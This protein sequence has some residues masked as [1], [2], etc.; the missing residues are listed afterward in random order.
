MCWEPIK[1]KIDAMYDEFFKS[2]NAKDRY[3]ITK[4]FQILMYD[5]IPEIYIEYPAHYVIRNQTL[6][7]LSFE[8]HEFGFLEWQTLYKSSWIHEETSKSTKKSPIHFELGLIIILVL[9]KKKKIALLNSH[10]K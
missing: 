5:E 3:Q 6:Q 7:N 10:R 9:K 8:M 2:T 4:E 1:L